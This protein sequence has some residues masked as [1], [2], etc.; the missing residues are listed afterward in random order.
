MISLP[1]PQKDATV[2]TNNRGI[3]LLPVF[4]KMFEKI[5][6]LREKEW[7]FSQEI[8]NESQGAGREQISCLH[9][10]FLTQKSISYNLQVH[11]KAFS[12]FM[13]IMKAFDCV[14]LGATHN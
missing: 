4:Y 8:M 9:T 1:K 11:G 13:D 14:W 5:V 2:K 6:L 12:T 10:S 7:L 3:T